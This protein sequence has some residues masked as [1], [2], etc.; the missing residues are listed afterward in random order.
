MSLPKPL[1][2]SVAIE[3]IAGLYL[4]LF[5][6]LLFGLGLLHWFGLLLFLLLNI[7]LLFGSMGKLRG[8]ERTYMKAMSSINILG[9]VLFILDA[10]LGLPFTKFNPGISLNSSL[11][12]SYLFGFGTNA[13]SSF[14]TSL[15]FTVLLLTALI[16]GISL[17]YILRK[18]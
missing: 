4:L 14:G 6:K 1:Y 12:W 13:V 10:A 17:A 3:F 5:D 16:S 2:L 15:G 9:F 7:I 11:G 18:S 8:T